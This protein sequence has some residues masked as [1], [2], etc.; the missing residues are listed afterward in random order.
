[1]T[2]SKARF[3]Q[4]GRVPLL[5]PWRRHVDTE[6]EIATAAETTVE[7][8]ALPYP[9]DRPSAVEVPPIY[10]SLRAQCPVARVKF[11]SG[12]E[13]YIASRYQDVYTVLAD[14]RFSRAATVEPDAPKLTATV[15]IPGS[16]FT[17]DP[18][19]HT[20]LRKLVS[21]EFTARRVQG[22]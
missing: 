18:P 21:R 19:E 6:T 12:D 17:M 5:R 13:G 15:P 9:F 8:P 10:D 3:D 1:M 16:L 22:M 11:P 14:P 2:R 20:R 4:R 7:T